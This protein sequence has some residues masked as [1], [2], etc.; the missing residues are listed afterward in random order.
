MGREADVHKDRMCKHC[1]K[2]VYG[3]ALKLVEHSMSCQRLQKIGLEMP[4]IET[5]RPIIP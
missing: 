4:M 5:P 1:G 2:P 3:L